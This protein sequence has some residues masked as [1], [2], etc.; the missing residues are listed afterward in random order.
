MEARINTMRV[1][2]CDVA[3]ESDWSRQYLAVVSFKLC[4]MYYNWAGEP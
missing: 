1:N 3:E 4:H 2:D